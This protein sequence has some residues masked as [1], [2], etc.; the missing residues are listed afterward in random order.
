MNE[1]TKKL[2]KLVGKKTTKVVSKQSDYNPYK[3]N[4]TS[5]YD[6]N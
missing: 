2:Q 1:T 6:Y 3:N 4:K 5:D